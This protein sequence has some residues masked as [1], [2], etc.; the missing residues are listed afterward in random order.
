[1]NIKDTLLVTTA[2][3]CI[4]LMG[5]AIV[6]LEFLHWPNV[7]TLVSCWEH[8]LTAGSYTGPTAPVSSDAKTVLQEPFPPSCMLWWVEWAR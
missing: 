5:A 4:L 8:L 6:G 3:A 7:Y 1:M 2:L